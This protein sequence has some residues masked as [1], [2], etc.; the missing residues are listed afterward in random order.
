MERWYDV[1]VGGSPSLNQ[2]RA[3]G[4]PGVRGRQGE[5]KKERA[6]SFCQCHLVGQ[7]QIHEPEHWWLGR[8][9]GIP[10]GAGWSACVVS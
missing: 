7:T 10:S 4:E 9:R 8:K 3:S 5:R 1:S 2:S 6:K